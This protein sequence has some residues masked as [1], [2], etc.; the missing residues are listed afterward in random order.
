MGL[1][2]AL[3]AQGQSRPSPR[4]TMRIRSRCYGPWEDK[5]TAGFGPW[6]VG[7]LSQTRC[8]STCDGMLSSFMRNPKGRKSITVSLAR[9]EQQ[10]HV[11]PKIASPPFPLSSQNKLKSVCCGI[12]A[13]IVP[14]RLQIGISG[15]GTMWDTTL[16]CILL[17]RLG[18]LEHLESSGPGS[19]QASRRSPDKSLDI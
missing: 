3:A 16:F 13:P 12:L 4:S 9:R 17:P 18:S 5:V 15:I 11:R 19:K 7:Y 6:S 8:S 10:H 1:R 2:E 14:K